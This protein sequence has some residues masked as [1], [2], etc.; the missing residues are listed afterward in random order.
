MVPHWESRRRCPTGKARDGTPLGKHGRHP[1]GKAWGG[2]PLGKA[3]A[4][5]HWESMGST[6]LGKHGQHPTGKAWAAPQPFV[7]SLSKYERMTQGAFRREESQNH[8][9]L[10]VVPTFP[11]ASALA[12]PPPAYRA[13]GV[14]LQRRQAPAVPAHRAARRPSRAFRTHRAHR[15]AGRSGLPCPLR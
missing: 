3:W 2:A 10:P 12:S 1:T 5:P 11:T 7:L 6:P 4:A 8:P 9:S 15:G 13:T 14:R